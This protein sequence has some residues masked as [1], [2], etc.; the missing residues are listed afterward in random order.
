[1]INLHASSKSIKDKPSSVPPLMVLVIAGE[2]QVVTSPY[3]AQ[4]EAMIEGMVLG[5]HS[6]RRDHV[7]AL[8]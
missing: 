7:V 2:V 5:L 8:S 6:S 4:L 1:M 3:D